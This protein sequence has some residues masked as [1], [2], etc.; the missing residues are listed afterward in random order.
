MASKDLDRT[1]S[2]FLNATKRIRDGLSVQRGRV[3]DAYDNAPRVLNGEPHEWVDVSGFHVNDVDYYAYELVRLRDLAKSARRPLGFPPELQDA[4]DA[5]DIALPR[6]LAYRHPTTHFTDT[7]DLDSVMVL[8]AAL[9]TD[10]DGV[11]LRVMVDP[12][13]DHDH[14]A[15]MALLNVLD[16]I[17]LERLAQSIADDPAKPLDEQ[18]RIRNAKHADGPTVS[19]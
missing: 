2:R 7:P 4:L 10:D 13:S 16:E 19:T 18:I 17:L 11:S 1:V 9:E 15:A 6:L 14:A 3:Q 5:F 8:S 12:K